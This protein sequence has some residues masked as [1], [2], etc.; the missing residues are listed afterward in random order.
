[1]SRRVLDL[2]ATESIS[3]TPCERFVG[4]PVAAGQRRRNLTGQQADRWL[5]E[6]AQS[7]EEKDRP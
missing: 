3:F 2:R 1:M 5:L 6:N 4:A 7:G